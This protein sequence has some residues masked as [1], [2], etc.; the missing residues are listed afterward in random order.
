[1][2]DHPIEALISSV[3][4]NLK[5]MVDANTVIGESI[6]TP[7]GVTIIPVTKLACGF[8]CGGGEY[9]QK[10]GEDSIPFGGGTGGGISL[11]PLGFI[12]I[13]ADGDKVDF[14][15]FK[16]GNASAIDTL[17]EGASN[18]FNNIKWHKKK[19]KTEEAADEVVADIVEEMA[20]EK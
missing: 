7:N 4:E 6:V 15:P 5:K 8:G 9:A 12:Y 18:L 17:F 11:N 10:A 1:M 2:R 16:E 13:T 20:E 14:I 3:L 19:G